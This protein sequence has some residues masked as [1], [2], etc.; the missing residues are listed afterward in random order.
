MASPMASPL[1]FQNTAP[2]GP[3]AYAIADVIDRSLRWTEN[4]TV[5]QA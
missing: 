5:L 4:F 3:S 2:N 1:P